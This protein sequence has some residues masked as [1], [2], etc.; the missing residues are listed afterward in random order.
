[1]IQLRYLRITFSATT[2]YTRLREA[3]FYQSVPGVC[4][5]LYYLAQ[6]GSAPRM[7]RFPLP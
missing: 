6:S 5:L 1:M 3:R 7:Q 2:A 4:R